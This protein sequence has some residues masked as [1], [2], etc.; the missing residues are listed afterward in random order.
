MNKA[1][2]KPKIVHETSYRGCGLSALLHKRRLRQIINILHKIIYERKIK[3]WADFGCSNGFIIAEY[4][5]THVSNT[6]SHIIGYDRSN[7]LLKLAK[8]R[9]LKNTQFLPFDL[10]ADLNLDPKAETKSK[11]VEKFELVTCFETLEHVGNLSNALQN[12]LAHVKPSGTLIISV[13][14]EI[15]LPGLLKFLARYAL[16]RNPYG[17]FFKNQSPRLYFK[18]LLLNRSITIFRSKDSPG[19]GPHLGFDYRDVLN[20]IGQEKDN[21]RLESCT[22]IA[23]GMGYILVLKRL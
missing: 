17:D 18:N 7:K 12:I 13:P 11:S 21:F 19:F 8:A 9:S 22:P 16:R 20:F 2:I 23:L 14:V 4:L 6:P 3:S 15:G 5:A 1:I 10:N